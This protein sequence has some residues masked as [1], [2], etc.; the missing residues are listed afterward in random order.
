MAAALPTVAESVGPNFRVRRELSCADRESWTCW[1]A[2]CIIVRVVRSAN[3]CPAWLPANG[4]DGM[5][6]FF[7][8]PVAMAVLLFAVVVTLVAVGVYIVGRFR[9][10]DEQD[11]PIASDMMTNL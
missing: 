11:Q 2:M 6:V 1:C 8:P 5:D 10:H 3:L 7:K 9:G 4:V